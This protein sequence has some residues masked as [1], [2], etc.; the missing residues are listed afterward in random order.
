MPQP[1][2]HRRV[3]RRLAIFLLTWLLA[4]MTFAAEP[5]ARPQPWIEIGR[6][7][8][9]L[10]RHSKSADG[11]NALAWTVSDPT[12]DWPLLES[13][14]DAF[15]TKYD[16]REIWVVDLTA[17]KK[18]GVLGGTGSYLRP[19]SHRTLSVAWGP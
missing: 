12:P 13:D 16:A 4:E 3:R 19:G 14:A 6:E 2:H 9:V 5:A 11:R 8:A 15:Y 10:A 18:L 1:L 7:R 17:A